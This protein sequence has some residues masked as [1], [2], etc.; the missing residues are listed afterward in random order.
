[1]IDRGEKRWYRELNKA[2][3]LVFYNVSIKQSDLYIG[4]TIKKDKFAKIALKEARN[5]VEYEIQLRPEFLTSYEPLNY[6]GGSSNI[7]SWMYEASSRCKVGPMAAVAGATARYVG[8]KL[9]ETSKEVIVENGGDLFICTESVRRVAIYAGK[10]PL[11]NKIAIK[12]EPGKWGVCTS[13]RTIGHSYSSGRADAA[14]CI[15]ADCALADAAATRLGNSITDE[16]QLPKG[17]KNIINIDGIIAAV[18][19]V[20]DK[21]AVAGE[22]ELMPIVGG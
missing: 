18:A 8:E 10:S 3:D 16:N 12:I 14:V 2:S 21:I 19:I 4:S 5:K 9:C 15:S 13:A 20:G 1:M 22:L 17:V 7:V 11:S 6:F